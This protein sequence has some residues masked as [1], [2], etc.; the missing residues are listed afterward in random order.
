MAG[1]SATPPSGSGR[2]C[3][4]LVIGAGPGGYVAAIRAGQL[5]KKVLL[6]ERDRLGGECLNYGCIPSKALLHV[7]GLKHKVERAAEM[8]L[9]VSGVTIDL[10]QLQTWKSGV[11]ERLTNGVATL[12]KGNGVEVVKGEARFSGPHTLLVRSPGG[13]E[14]IE[15]ANII[16]AT[17]GRPV[18]LPSF[19]FDRKRILSS[20]EILELTA[21]PRELLVIGGGITGLEMGTFYAKLGTQVTV[22]ELLDQILPGVDAEVIR[23]LTRSLKKLGMIVHVSS[24]VKSWEERGEKLLVHAD[25][26]EGPI[27]V[28]CEKVLVAV[29]RRANSDWLD[30]ES[31]GVGMDP[32]G[33]V[34]V[35]DQMRTNVPHIFAI[36]DLRGPPYLAHKASREGVVAAEA[37]CGLSTAFDARAMPSAIFTDPEIALVGITEAEASAK[38]KKVRVGKVP[39]AALG[40]TLTAG[41][42]E[43]FTKL[44]VDEVSGRILGAQIIG[45]DAS[46]II[47]ELALAIEM[48]ATAEDVALTI[49]PH[50]TFPEG[51]LEA[52]EAALGRAIHV[53]NKH[54]VPVNKGGTLK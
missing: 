44:V 46:D 29:G 25:T 14:T 51:I 2:S 1:H 40:R 10:P 41:E 6:V 15:A 7:A 38:G 34:L 42:S 13:V 50:P 20:K 19:R 37:A 22:I 54:D 31:V 3:D 28:L 32:K 12:C 21:I 30:L 16:L 48:G 9:K 11:V 33:H 52:A 45:P 17:G 27:Q 47:S 24:K 8:G 53:L 36:G 35:D 49:H 43:G 4:V 39:F 26:P 18:D 23:V 5:G